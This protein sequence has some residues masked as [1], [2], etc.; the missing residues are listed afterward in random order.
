MKIS[1]DDLR[2]MRSLIQK[3]GWSEVMMNI[4]SILAEQGDKTEGDQGSALRA[5]SQTVHALHSAWEGCGT[6]E[7][8]PD[9]VDPDIAG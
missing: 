5:C 4:G 7:Y 9:M 3:I 6:F 1:Q 8:P 2:I